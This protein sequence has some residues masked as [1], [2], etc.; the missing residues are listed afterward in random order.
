MSVPH[1]ICICSGFCGA[2]KAEYQVGDI[3]AARAVQQLG[4][5][6]TIQC[7]RGLVT[8]AMGD[9]AKIAGKFFSAEELSRLP[10]KRAR[11]AP[12]ADAV[13]MESY[14]HSFGR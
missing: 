1:T 7:S 5:N 12:F 14:D 8:N 10:R 9:G 6:R 4:K 13:D 11:L 3:L 2:L